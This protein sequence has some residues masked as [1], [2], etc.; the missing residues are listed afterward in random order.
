MPFTPGPWAARRADSGSLFV[1]AGRS[2]VAS[3]T[4]VTHVHAIADEGQ[5]TETAL[6]NLRLIAAA[7]DLYAMLDRLAP[8][9]LP[10]DRQRW[11]ELKAAIE[12]G[13]I[14]RLV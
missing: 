13:K 2:F 3:P 1:T 6:A 14:E 7:P 8:D 4:H 5:P 12:A 10:S 11:E 9:M